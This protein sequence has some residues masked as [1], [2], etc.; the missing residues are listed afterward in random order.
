M[1]KPQPN[2]G[3]GADLLKAGWDDLVSGV[4]TRSSER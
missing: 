2:K 4:I 3:Q 1:R